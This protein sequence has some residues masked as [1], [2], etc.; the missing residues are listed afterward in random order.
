MTADTREASEK[1]RGVSGK[2]HP[3]LNLTTTA[4]GAFVNRTKRSM[5]HPVTGIVVSEVCSPIRLSAKDYRDAS[6]EDYNEHESSI[7]INTTSVGPRQPAQKNHV[8]KQ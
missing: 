6:P 4:Y 2:T 7:I 1:Y 3:S 5:N 8:W